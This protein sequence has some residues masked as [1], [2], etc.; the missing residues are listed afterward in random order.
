MKTFLLGVGAQKAGTTWLHD[1]LSH[2]PQADLG[3][4][5]EYHVFD[6][7]TLPGS[8]KFRKLITRQ[9]IKDL[10][11]P[12]SIGTP[13]P[14]VTR[15]AFLYDQEIY[16][17]YFAGLLK[18]D[19]IRLTGDITPSY[20]GLSEETLLRIRDGFAARGIAVK[21]VFLMRDPV[22][23]LQSMVRMGFRERKIT[24]DYD[25]EVRMMRRR[26]RAPGAQVRSDYT[27][28][29]NPSLLP[30]SVRKG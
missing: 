15:A 29:D 16:F 27:T 12:H 17:D 9:A 25:Q 10:E 19:G 13:R 21:P 3:F 8:T 11:D 14:S 6:S 5:K 22:D 2:S 20:S 4:T 18:R 1:Y 28:K 24:P 26:M 7:L 30:R 23:R